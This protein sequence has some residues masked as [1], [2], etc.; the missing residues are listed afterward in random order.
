MLSAGRLPL[1]DQKDAL[2]DR[3]KEVLVL[4]A[5]GK[6]NKEIA[7]ILCI[8]VFTVMTHRKNISKKL[9]INNIAGLAVYAI[10]NGLIDLTSLKDV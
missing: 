4:V 5:K 7:D 1:P 9:G 10:I 8:S 6:M 2:S 3:E